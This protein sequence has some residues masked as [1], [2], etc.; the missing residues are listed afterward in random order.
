V[1]A[2]LRGSA[3]RSL[4]CRGTQ[5]RLVQV[6]AQPVCFLGSQ[7]QL[8]AG[9]GRMAD[10]QLG[11]GQQPKHERAEPSGSLASISASTAQIRCSPRRGSP[12]RASAHPCKD[13]AGIPRLPEPVLADSAACS[14]TESRARV[15]VSPT[16]AQASKN[17]T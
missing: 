10:Q 4:A 12:L 13:C 15:T 2:G 11:L 9:L 17:R 8:V 16:V 1:A 7:A 5:L 14:A 6:L 3:Y